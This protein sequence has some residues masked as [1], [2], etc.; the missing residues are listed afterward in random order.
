MMIG[1]TIKQTAAAHPE[2]VAI[3]CDRESVTYKALDEDINFL[4]QQIATVLGSPTGKK[5]AFLLE[6]DQQFLTTFLAISQIEAI[7]IPLDSKW[8][9]D[10]LHYILTDCNPDLIIG[11]LVFPRIDSLSY[12]D[13][14]EKKGSSLTTDPVITEDPLFYIGYTSGTTGKPKGYVRAQSSWI[15]SFSVSNQVFDIKAE[16]VICAPGPLVHSHFLY[17]ALHA[18]HI[19]ATIYITKKF[20]ANAVHQTLLTNP[21]SILYL[22]P[23]M[24]SALHEVYVKTKIP[25]KHLEKVI[26]A[27][28]KWHSKEKQKAKEVIPHAEVFEFYGASELSLVSVLDEK[29]YHEHSESVGRPVPG[30]EVVIRRLDGKEAKAGEIGKLFVKSKLLFSGYHNQQAATNEVFHGDWV[31]VGDLGF[32]NEK[33]YITLVGREKN[34]IISGGLNIYPE[35]VEKVL[36]SLPEIDEVIVIGLNDSYWGEKLVAVIKW[37]KGTYLA[38]KQ[39]IQHCKHHLASYKCPKQFIELTNFPYTTSQKIARKQVIKLIEH[40][41]AART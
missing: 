34:M 32:M 2:K 40:K 15:H 22:V 30:V 14:I 36:S 11:E 3:Y 38:D 10:D 29:G 33:G 16:D 20:D 5:V 27:G 24:F 1:K 12:A 28:A 8:K 17:A 18:L 19:G 26:S 25:I 39:L 4:K 37:H 9:Q 7:A 21:I 13:L 31:T 23:T 6:N 41:I 35:E